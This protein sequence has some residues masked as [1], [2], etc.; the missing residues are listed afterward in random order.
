MSD[1]RDILRRKRE[2]DKT[3]YQRG[4]EEGGFA[5]AMSIAL[6]FLLIVLVV[7]PLLD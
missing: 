1:M 5:G 3:A 7:I 4:F 6:V 2:R